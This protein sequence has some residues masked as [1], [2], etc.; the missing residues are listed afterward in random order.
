MKIIVV[1]CG[2]IGTTILS[3]LAFEGHDVVAID[4]LPSVI[5]EI[6][7]IYD[8]MGVCGNGV[9]Y[10]TLSEAGADK[11]DIF[12]ASTGSDELN[13]L[14][15]FIARKMGAAHTIAKVSNPEYNDRNSAFMQKELGL[16]LAVN[17]ALLAAHEIY[18]VLGLPSAAKIETFSGRRYEIVELVLRSDS[19]LDGMSLIELRKKYK[20]DFLVCVVQRDE[21]VYIPDGNFVLRSGDRIALTASPG[22]MQK[23]MKMLGLMQKPIR[24]VMILGASK[25]AFY[26]SKMLIDGGSSVKIVE[27]DRERCLEFS[28]KLGDV[29]MFHGDGARQ[30]LLLEEGLPS[31]D[32]FVTLT[33]M[34]E[35]NMLLSV[36]ASSLGLS[37]VVTKVNRDEFSSLAKKL[38]LDCIISPSKSVSDVIVSYARALQNSEGSSNIETLYKLMDGKAEAL[39]FSVRSDFSLC[40]IPLRDMSLKSGILIGGIIRSRRTIIPKGDD[41]ILPGDKVIVVAAGQRLDDLADIIK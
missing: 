11:A 37:K 28:E 17:P 39:E 9:D 6:T 10:E 40:G 1:G 14:A 20:A 12:I 3:S 16:S 15:C 41:V 19:P 21:Q 8:V 13:M 27:L 33:G 31:M 29:S 35:E 5:S 18:N 32:A 2:K 24:D 26:L 36:F 7:N 34:D 38:G 30:E 23:L 25:A 4:N 22:E